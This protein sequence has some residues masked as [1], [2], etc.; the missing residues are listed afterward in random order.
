[1]NTPFLKTGK[2]DFK[3]IEEINTALIILRHFIE[4]N[5]KLLPLLHSLHTLENPS[6][7]D[8]EDKDKIK[9][10]FSTYKFE[11]NSSILLMNSPI[12]EIIQ[13]NYISI[14]QN[15]PEQ[16]TSYQLKRFQKEYAK[17]VENWNLVS[18]S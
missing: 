9:A 17:L 3:A 5:A 16:E 18:A 2:L 1:M 10:V 4:L 6:K 8:I 11:S 13:M 7:R 15:A 14:F 12:L